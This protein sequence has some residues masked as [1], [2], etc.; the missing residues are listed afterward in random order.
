[1]GLSDWAVAQV[2]EE[3]ASAPLEQ[4]DNYVK[5]PTLLEP[6]AARAR[7]WVQYNVWD[8]QTYGPYKGRDS[9]DIDR[10]TVVLYYLD[11]NNEW[12]IADTDTNGAYP[13]GSLREVKPVVGNSFDKGRHE[14]II[15]VEF[16][17]VTTGDLSTEVMEIKTVM[18][19][20]R[21]GQET[22]PLAPEAHFGMPE[23]K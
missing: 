19:P 2:H 17:R 15:F 1:M 20:L 3:N 21:P 16:P 6:G 7:I 12:K 18:I 8:S 9:R 5:F 13:D 11:G 23:E 4:R 10:V 22:V 14:F